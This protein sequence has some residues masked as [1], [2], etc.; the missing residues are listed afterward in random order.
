VVSSF[1][2]LDIDSFAITRDDPQMAPVG[3]QTDIE[4]IVSPEAVSESGPTADLYTYVE[5]NEPNVISQRSSPAN[6]GPQNSTG[7]TFPSP[8]DES[9]NNAMS[10]SSQERRVTVDQSQSGSGEFAQANTISNMSSFPSNQ[11]PGQL[12]LQGWLNHNLGSSTNDQPRPTGMLQSNMRGNTP[13]MQLC[14]PS[15]NPQTMPSE[16]SD[17]F[18]PMMDGFDTMSGMMG[19]SMGLNN[20]DDDFWWARSWGSVKIL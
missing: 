6:A 8:R 18:R 2:G 14:V 9:N 13:Q 5:R 15:M 10:H 12:P 17:A 4:K 11:L 16:Q 20:E 7:Q 19:V 1:A 3:I